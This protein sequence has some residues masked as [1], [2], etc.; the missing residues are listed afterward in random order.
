M[1]I[2]T[3][4]GVD[5]SGARLAGKNIWLAWT[6]ANGE[7]LQLTRLARLEDLAGTAERDT[8]L[9]YLVELIAASD[10]TLWG[11]D[12]PF[13][14]PVELWKTGFSWTEQLEHIAACELDAPAFGRWCVEVAL[15]QGDRLHIRRSTDSESK[16][17]FDCYHY[18][19]IYQTFHGMR[20]VL[21]PLMSQPGTAIPPFSSVKRDTR[22]IVV[23]ACPSST[24]K[25]LALPHQNYKQPAGGPLLLKRRRTRHAILDGLAEFIEISTADRRIIQRN[26]GG[27]ALDA[28]IA[29]VGTAQSWK[30]ADHAAIAVHP[31]YSREGLVFY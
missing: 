11:I 5:F 7:R 27:D 21:R 2:D 12:F 17:P 9:Q 14:L 18:R 15:Q 4:V 19:I 13:G 29:A 8:A 23:E 25:R 26:P 6:E 1:K 22:R 10:H 3:V 31:R 24:L 20:D 16:T 28:V 30:L